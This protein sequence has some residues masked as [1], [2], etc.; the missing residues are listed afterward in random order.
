M[1]DG[2]LIRSLTDTV[3]SVVKSGYDLGHTHICA[4]CWN[5]FPCETPHDIQSL[6]SGPL[7]CPRCETG[8]SSVTLPANWACIAIRSTAKFRS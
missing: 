6:S 3:T 4:N 8:E 5:E 1:Y 2:N 7:V